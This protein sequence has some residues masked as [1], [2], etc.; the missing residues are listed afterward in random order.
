MLLVPPCLDVNVDA[1]EFLRIVLGY[2]LHEL[3]VA[4]EFLIHDEKLYVG[5]VALVEVLYA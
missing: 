4:K 2:P 3:T 5:L 1:Y